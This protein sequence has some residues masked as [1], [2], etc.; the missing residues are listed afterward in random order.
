MVAAAWAGAEDADLVV[1]LVDAERGIGQETPRHHRAAE[2]EQGAALS[3][4]L[5]KVD[6]VPREKL[7]ALTDELQRAAAFE[8]PS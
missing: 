3:W 5:N 1:L 8:T 4:S 2:G 6:L 7:L